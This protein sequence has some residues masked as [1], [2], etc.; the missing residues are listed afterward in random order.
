MTDLIDFDL[1]QSSNGFTNVAVSP[2]N[3]LAQLLIELGEGVLPL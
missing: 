1:F 3:V 2:Q